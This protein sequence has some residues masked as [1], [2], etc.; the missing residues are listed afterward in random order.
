M[1]SESESRTMNA[2]LRIVSNIFKPKQSQR[3]F[4]VNIVS[5]K[6]LYTV[7]TWAKAMDIKSYRNEVV[8]VYS[9]YSLIDP[10]LYQLLTA[11]ITFSF[12]IR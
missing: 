1:T 3:R 11:H 12:Q 5:F 2:L 10:Y 7:L 6:T 4:L 9:R 8:A